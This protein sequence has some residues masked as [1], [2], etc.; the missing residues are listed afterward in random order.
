MAS[1]SV[2]LSEV[3]FQCCIC[4]DVFLEPVS[5]P[6]GH[7]FCF[8]CITSH[9][10]DN[11]AISCP[12]CQ[13]EFEGRPELCENSFAKEMSQ[14]IRI[15]RQNDVTSVE[16][17][18]ICCDVCVGEQTKALKSCLICLTSYCEIHLEPHL[19]VSTLKIHKLIEP[20]AMLHNRICKQHH[21]LLELFC[22]NDR[23]CVCVLCTETDHR[24]HD[25]VPVE[26][27]SQEMKA[28]IK[29]IDIDVQQMIQDRQQKVKEIKHN[30][31]LSKENSK[32]D[33]E[34]SVEVFSA[35]CRTMERSQVEL[36]EM[37]QRKQA[38]AEQRAERFVAELEQEITELQ[39]KSSE[40]EQ[41]FHTED[42]LHVVQR[43]PAVHSAPSAKA[44]SDIFVYSDA[45]MGA[46]RRAMANVQK[47]LQSELTK[48]SIR[49]HEKIQGY[50][51][52]V[53]LDPRTA[54]PWLVLS[55]DGRQVQDGDIEQNLPDIPARFDTAPCVLAL[56]GFTTGR[57]YWEVDVG[58]KTAW[59]LGVARESISRK[60]VVTLSPD[61]GYW[62]VCLRKGSEYRA[63]AGQ[64]E[65]L[66][67]SQKPHVIGVLLDY[68]DGA[69]S[70]YDAEAK[71]HIYSF[72]ELH[73]TE[74]MFPFFNPDMNDNGSNKSPLIIHPVDGMD[75][76]RDLDGITI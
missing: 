42:H 35:L 70:F 14:Q 55:E 31:E 29:R 41:L 13:T 5:I 63:C 45:C 44:C 72:K 49:E 74:A 16:G 18:T 2:L 4:Q 65:L 76:G 71:T 46:M 75:G 37:I 1:P 17:K 9:W 25:T 30:V 22:R 61:E 73:F 23:R 6:C 33:I 7:S 11:L 24:S 48:L 68:E 57:H 19:R 47:Q 67:L 34:E 43:F 62:T 3:Q 64:A 26:R 66:W 10:D 53:R 40:M 27:E 39:K 20:V 21:R 8:T 38:A 12:R 58:D 28:Q 50:A 51:V 52:D 59:D 56:R 32:R 54:N 15:R 36:V 69:V 60:G